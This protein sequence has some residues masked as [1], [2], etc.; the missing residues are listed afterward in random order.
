MKSRTAGAVA[1]SMLIATVLGSCAADDAPG[2]SA[3]GQPAHLSA[4]ASAPPQYQRVAEWPRLPD[5]MEF[6]DMSGVDVDSD[7]HVMVVHRGSREEV[8]EGGRI[9]EP[10]VVTLHS[11]TGEVLQTWGGDTFLNPHGLTID[12]DGSVWITDTGLH[13][14]FKFT[15]DGELLLTLGEAEVPGWD[16][17]HFNRPTQVAV[18][19][20]GSFYVADGY[21]NSRVAKFDGDGNFLFEWGEAGEG[22]GQ[23]DNPHGITL[24]PD[25]NL[26]VSD[27]ENSRVQIFDLEGNFI[28]EWLGAE[29]TGRVFSATVGP[30]EFV[31]LAIRPQGRDA[32]RTGVMKLN[33]DFEIVAQI[34][35]RETGDAVFQS[36][37]YAAV[38]AGGAVYLAE[39]PDRRVSKYV[40]VGSTARGEENEE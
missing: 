6:G 18:L 3:Q 2:Q 12:H 26:L 25:G 35:F 23:F 4:L 16:E 13:Q 21:V 10:V 30:D 36:A 17:G 11:E 39:T 14:V 5:G 19:P 8:P 33:R 27:R 32:L 37:H 24:G 20:D 28:E 38:G 31:Y 29:P 22:P 7:G 40:P 34:G 9:P 1:S 15:H